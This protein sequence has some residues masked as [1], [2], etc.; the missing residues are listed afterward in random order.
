MDGIM[1]VVSMLKGYTIVNV[2]LLVIGFVMLIKGSDIF[3]EGAS[4]IAAKF[5]IPQIII[6][7]TIVA[8]GTSAPEAA[9]SVSAAIKGGAGITIGNVLGSNIMNILLIL[10]VASLVAALP[11]KKNTIRIEIPFVIAVSIL[12]L[13][14]GVM[15]G[16]FYKVDG[17]IFWLFFAAFFVY[18][19]KSAKNGNNEEEIELN[20]KDTMLKMI[21]LTVVGMVLI[22]WGSDV[23]VD[24]ASFIADKAGMSQ[25][26]IGLTIVAFGTSLPELVT[27]VIAAKKGK[28]DIA[29]GNIV[30]SNIFNIL[31]VL[32]TVCL[33]TPNPLDFNGFLFDSIAAII[34]AVMLLVF[35]IKNKKLGRIGGITMLVTYA[36][37]FTYIII[38]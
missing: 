27:S 6:G 11:V 14:L 17:V 3:V 35:V 21:L 7:L 5:N 19:I 1:N 18:L 12:L 9:V 13:L 30:G 15:D 2:I 16:E 24:A 22:V 20:P 32:G 4:K 36:A 8:F 26:L 10:G 33:V 34:A 23:T 25:R 28:T 31:F 37:Y 29:I 38:K